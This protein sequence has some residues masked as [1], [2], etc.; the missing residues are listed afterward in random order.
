MLRTRI[1]CAA[2]TATIIGAG[3]PVTALNVS[4]DVSQY[5]HAKWTLRDGGLPGYPRSIAQTR[6][7]FLWLA[8]DFGLQRFDGVRFSPWESPPG[9]SLP[10]VAVGLLA[11][12]DGSLWIGTDQ[13]FGA[14]ERR[15]ALGL[16]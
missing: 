7:G 8:T 14:L 2:V 10:G 16:S 12:R 11:T 4:G 15:R 3:T 13:G 1:A 6:D 9:S 5:G